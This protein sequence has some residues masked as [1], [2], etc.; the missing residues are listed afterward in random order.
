MDYLVTH[1]MS[2]SEKVPL[3]RPKIKVVVAGCYSH[4]STTASIFYNLFF[5]I[6]ILDERFGHKIRM[7]SL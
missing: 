1:D 4:L 6:I 2:K 3:A 7:L 5:I